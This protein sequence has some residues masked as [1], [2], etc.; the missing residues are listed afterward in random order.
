MK[1][2]FAENLQKLR[3]RAGYTQQQLANKI[4]VDRSTIARWENGSRIPDLSLLK[5]I[6]ACLN[7]ELLEL[8]NE[9]ETPLPPSIIMVDDEKAILVGSMNVVRKTIPSALVTGFSK[10]SEALKYVETSHVDLAF[11]DIAMGKTSGIDLCEAM[12]ALQP[13]LNV[14][15]LTAY[16]EFS[17][18]SWDTHACGFLVKPLMADDIKRQLGRLRYP[19]SG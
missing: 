16:P 8:V 9:T 10:P 6:A 4:N 14:V 3:M 19:I 12:I 1:E 7:V 2:P 11:V 17:L 5:K 18:H 13:R 15:F